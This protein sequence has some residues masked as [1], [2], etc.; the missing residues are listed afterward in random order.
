MNE[1]HE[2]Q[3]VRQ[4]SSD[5]VQDNSALILAITV[6]AQVMGVLML[7]CAILWH[8]IGSVFVGGL[9]PLWNCGGTD[10]FHNDNQGNH[11]KLVYF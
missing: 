7:F 11:A 8:V 2:P 5:F 6:V 10:Q 9:D 4:T 1:Q 3:T